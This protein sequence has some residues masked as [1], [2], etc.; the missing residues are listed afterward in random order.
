MYI[1]YIPSLK[2]FYSC[3]FYVVTAYVLIFCLCLLVIYGLELVITH[4]LSRFLPQYI[5]ER[6][7]VKRELKSYDRTAKF[8]LCHGLS[9]LGFWVILGV[10]YFRHYPIFIQQC[11]GYELRFWLDKSWALQHDKFT[12]FFEKVDLSVTDRQMDLLNLTA[13]LSYDINYICYNLNSPW[14]AQPAKAFGWFALVVLFFSLIIF[15]SFYFQKG[16]KRLIPYV[17]FI[18]SYNGLPGL[19]FLKLLYPFIFVLAISYFFYRWRRSRLT[20]VEYIGKNLFSEDYLVSDIVHKFK[21]FRYYFLVTFFGGNFILL[22]NWFIFLSSFVS[23]RFSTLGI[24]QLIQAV[25]EIQVLKQKVQNLP[26]SDQQQW[27][28]RINEFELLYDKLIAELQ[29]LETTLEPYYAF[30]VDPVGEL[31]WLPLVRLIFLFII[32]FGFYIRYYFSKK[33]VGG[34]V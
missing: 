17:L 27:S 33:F 19:L 11:E 22:L 16:Q 30:E 31:W 34:V 23:Y 28:D 1:I 8:L 32:W 9:M 29:Y 21:F 7:E 13:K 18:P 10:K 3:F 4:P 5:L 6:D 25:P 26:L 14:V 12:Y 15:F 24:E 20:L 2:F